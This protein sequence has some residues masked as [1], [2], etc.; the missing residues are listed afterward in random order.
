M[1]KKEQ[2]KKSFPV[3]TVIFCVLI[4]GALGVY[5]GGV[6]YYQNHFV[7][8]TVI[9]KAD[10]SGMTLEEL[11]GQVQDYM[12]QITERK[13]DGSTLDDSGNLHRAWILFHGAAGNDYEGTECVAV[14]FETGYGA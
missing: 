13:S 7:N 6:F 12:L 1:K 14:V 11:S 8:G 10:V 2:N 9:D 3:L 4:L 5:A